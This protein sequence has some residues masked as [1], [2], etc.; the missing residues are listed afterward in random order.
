M[1][2]YQIYDSLRNQVACHQN[3]TVVAPSGNEQK[4]S[5]ESITSRI[6]SG[7]NKKKTKTPLYF[8][9]AAP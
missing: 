6:I 4:K 3:F 1:V 8:R 2:F 5:M 7:N 9:K